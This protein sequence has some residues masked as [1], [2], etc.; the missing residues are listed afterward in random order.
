[1][2]SVVKRFT[3]SSLRRMLMNNLVTATEI[4]TWARM[5]PRRAQE[6]LPELIVRLILSTSSKIDDYNFPIEK[7]I[8]FSGYDGVLNSGESTSYFP[9]GKSVWE[10]GTN[11]DSMSKFKEDIEKRHKNSLGVDV[12]ESTFIFS[13][14]KIWNHKT[15]IEELINE[16]KSKY[17]WKDIRI[18]DGAKIAMWLYSHT[19]VAVWFA[20]IIGKHIAGIRTI[21]SYWDDYAEHTLP[22]LNNEFF[23]LGRDVQSA[24]LSKWLE[25]G[26]GSLTVISESTIESV[27]FVAA[28][29][30]THEQYKAIMN[31][32]LVIE[33]PEE[34]NRLV[35]SNETNCLLIPVFNFTEDIR[36]PS[37]SF[38]LLPVAKYSPLS[39]ITKNVDS[40]KID[41]R[42]KA[43]YHEAL[44]TLGFKETEFTKIETETKR[45]FLPLYRQITTIVA[46]KK[47][48]WLSESMLDDLI[49]V[50]LAGGWN[51]SI[52]GDKKAIEILSGFKYEE[53]IQRINRWLSVEDA[54]IFKVFEVYQVVSVQDMWTFLFT[55]LT[56]KQIQRL[57]ECVLM[58]FGTEDPTFEL[59]EDQW[60]MA[61]IYGKSAPYSNL[62]CQGLTIS[63]I[64]LS[65][66]NTEDNNCNITSTEYYVYSLVRELLRAIN[67][68]QQWN[69]I[70]PM[71]TLLA[72]ASPSAFLE[73]IEH[74]VENEESEMWILFK[75]VADALW[76]RSYYT[77]IL[78]ALEQLVW[79]ENYVVR[80]ITVLSKIG[81]KK[82]KYS[83]QNSPINTLYE[84]F[85]TWHPQCCLDCGQRL[86]L[87]KKICKTY[88]YTGNELIAKLLP[89]G[90]S[91]CT[92]IQKPKWHTFEKEFEEKITVS[93]H[94]SILHTVADIAIAN[95]NSVDQ[96]IVIIEHASFFFG[97]VNFWIDRLSDFCKNL[98]ASELN[99]IATALRSEISKNRKFCNTDWAIP[100]KFLTR[101]EQV[102]TQILPN[103]YEQYVYL[104]KYNPDLLH[105]I[106][107]EEQRYDYVK[108]CNYLHEVQKSAINE[109]LEGYGSD[110][111]ITFSSNAY[112]CEMLTEVIVD[113]I[114]RNSYDFVL[115]FRIK[116]QNHQLSSSILWRLYRINGL[117]KLIEEL[118]SSTLTNA[119]YAGVLCQAP[120]DPNIWKRVDE[121]G[122][123]VSQYYWENISVYRLD[124]ELVQYWDF[125]LSQLLKYNR[126]FSAARVIEYSEYSNSTMIVSILHKCCEFQNYTEPTGASIK[127]LSEHGI[128]HLFKKLYADQNVELNT[129]VQLEIAYMPY[130]KHEW[131]PNGIN[132]YLSNNPIEFVELIAYNY[133][134]DPGF[135]FLAKEH[136]DNQ[137]SIAYDIIE[138]FKTVPGFDG[139][140]ISEDKFNAW[141]TTAQEHAKKIG[142]TN[143]FAF[144]FGRVLSYAPVGI[145]GIFPHEVIRDYFEHSHSE[146]LENGL[147]T[148]LHNQRG[149]HVVTGGLEEKEISDKYRVNASKIRISYPRSAALLDKIAQSYMQESLYE[150]KRELLDFTG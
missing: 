27:L 47:P 50:F 91:I 33:S 60:A 75:P 48:K 81:E 69:T 19:S 18:I 141:V 92:S 111:L 73:K 106:P 115:I 95:A 77:Y 113:K 130:L 14:L 142:Y 100:E 85:C 110:A 64:L 122:D 68:W 49:P 78:W 42:R 99:A 126:P 6:I 21:E 135:E 119:E 79:Y 128:R 147:I 15:S 107:Y 71:L 46:R 123:E 74:E 61:S 101:M 80:A 52:D 72:E 31:R 136:P 23:L 65:E 127:D 30:R 11:E 53:Y 8:Q 108:E 114:L 129:L 63:L 58:V 146:K 88:T 9:E 41:K 118:K 36:C 124:D 59:P 140:S 20:N 43:V 86:E 138:L 87:L 97:A 132:R 67:T 38:I 35:I 137:R 76:G 29:F 10:F 145:D 144:C 104:F 37:D 139:K 70:A 54:P 131:I 3:E 103:N 102:L 1:M 120:L 44:K 66:Q 96:W 17:N 150:Q 12:H 26:T 134:P 16:S 117:D 57:K 149:F 105:P 112:D 62:L 45:S 25:A 24:Y 143:S 4:D 28:Y 51:G 39:K 22:K 55:R 94:R 7:G 83:L 148:E 84:I 116:A 125:F 109:I 5:N 93:E 82:F 98:S 34:W 13:T 2:H 90:H 133:K 32:T 121:F 40:I 89:Q 56:T